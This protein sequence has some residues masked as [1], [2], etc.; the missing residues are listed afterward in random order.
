MYYNL[1]PIN[2]TLNKIVK[3]EIVTDNLNIN[4]YNTLDLKINPLNFSYPVVSVGTTTFS[5]SA[6]KPSPKLQYNETDGDFSYTLLAIM[7]MD[8]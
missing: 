8:L 4:N 7:Y 6:I 5:F 3:Q 1:I 2:G